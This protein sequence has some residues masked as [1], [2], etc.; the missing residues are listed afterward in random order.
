MLHNLKKQCIENKIAIKKNQKSSSKESKKAPSSRKEIFINFSKVIFMR[1]NSHQI[2]ISFFL[3]VS[4]TFQTVCIG[5]PTASELQN[6]HMS[7]VLVNSHS[8]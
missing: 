2:C 4:N 5:I 8:T 3:I 7:T 1:V 6:Q